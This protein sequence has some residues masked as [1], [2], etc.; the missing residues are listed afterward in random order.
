MPFAA[1]TPPRLSTLVLL[2]ALS[3]L[4][5]NMFLPSLANM[6]VDFEADYAL[7]TFAIAGYLGVTA[8]LMLILGPLSDRYGRRPVMLVSLAL[9]TV[10][11]L[12]CTLTGNIWVFLAFRVLQGAVIAGWGLSLTIT[13]DISGPEEAA[14]RISFITMAMSVA[15]MLGPVLGG[16]LDEMFGWRS[17]FLTFTILGLLAF[18]LCWVDMGETNR[19]KSTSFASQFRNYP[20]LLKNGRYWDYAISIAFAAGCFYIFLAGVPL[21]AVSMLGLSP[22]TLGFYMGLITLGFTVGTFFSGRFSQRISLNNLILIGRVTAMAG[23]LIG[24]LFMLS[25]VVNVYTLFA[26]VMIVGLGNGLSIPSCNAGALS[27]RP[28]LAGSALGLVGA[29]NVGFGA[30]MTSFTG[31]ILDNDHGALTLILLMSAA[32]FISLLAALHL[33]WLD[34]RK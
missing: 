2:T 22:A 29:M 18:L 3:V 9:F 30:F 14:K 4:S 16:G 28:D 10:A 32:T 17:S 25:G 7:L 1:T 5:L 8:V 34:R 15:P 23:L 31:T 19:Q 27:V 21:V 13:R 24:L 6:A 12:V 26:P 11:S 20:D 33:K